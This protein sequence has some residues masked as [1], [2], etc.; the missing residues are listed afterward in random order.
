MEQRQM[1]LGVFAVGTGNH[2]AGWRHPGAT[3]DAEDIATFIKIG[4][5]AERG[6]FGLMFLAD[7]LQCN[8][9]SVRLKIE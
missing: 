2:I 6:K 7:N 4:Q 3:Q 5:T 1:H 9:T 8:F